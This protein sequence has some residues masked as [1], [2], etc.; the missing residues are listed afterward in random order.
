MVLSKNKSNDQRATGYALLA[1]LFWS[2]IATAFKIG[3]KNLDPAQLI[4]IASVTTVVLLFSILAFTNKLKLLRQL[5]LKQLIVHALLGFL[6]PFLYY[7]VLFK[8][9]NLL[10]AQVAQPVNMVWPIVLVLLSV[11]MLNRS[12]GW[13]SLLAL[14]ISFFGVFLI[15]T[16]GSFFS[17]SASNPVG[18]FLCLGSSI[19]WSLYWILNLKSNQEDLIK[20]F[21]SFVFGSLFLLIYLMFFSSFTFKINASFA[22]GIYIGLFEVGISFVLWMK[23]MSLSTKHARIANLI[24][25]A[26][27]LSLVFIHFILGEKLFVTT[28]IGLIFIIAGIFYQQT[29]SHNIEV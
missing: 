16:Q 3:L 28:F 23:A 26:P 14:A 27:F 10:P 6:N 13:R 9:Y 2:T 29:D 19:V 12:I 15:S 25:I 18:I 24:Y 7:L 17:L 11:P 8:A 4:F 5:S 21:V 1:I 22:A 20:L